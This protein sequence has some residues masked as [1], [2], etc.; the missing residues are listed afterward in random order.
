MKWDLMAGLVGEELKEM[1]FDFDK[2]LS[3][4]LGFFS[5]G[6]FKSVILKFQ[7]TLRSIRL[8]GL[9]CIQDSSPAA[10]NCPVQFP[11]LKS[12]ILDN[13]QRSIF[14]TFSGLKA[15][16]NFKYYQSSPKTLLKSLSNASSLLSKSKAIP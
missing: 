13:C 11:N 3:R 4:G 1:S 8:S 7:S 9:N 10:Q 16:L 14:Q 5:S 15:V 12:L 6:A 2:P